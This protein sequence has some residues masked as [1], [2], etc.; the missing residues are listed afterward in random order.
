MARD[1]EGHTPEC[2]ILA[3]LLKNDYLSSLNL[4]SSCKME[5]ADQLPRGVEKVESGE[6]GIFLGSA[7]QMVTGINQQ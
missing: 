2:G 7:W 5:I 3:Q 6:N 1:L 4:F